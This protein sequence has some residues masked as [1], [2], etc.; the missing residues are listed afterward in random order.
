MKVA[1]GLNSCGLATLLFDLLT[2]EEQDDRANVF[3]IDLLA[4]RLFDTVV[5]LGREPKTAQLPFGLFG[6]STGSAA[7]L[8]AAARLGDAIQATISRGGRPDLA[9]HV[10]D[11]IRFPTLLIVGGVDF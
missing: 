2:G 9:D 5:W 10:L 1:E 8:V 7:A 11:Q 4:T 3:N 6:A